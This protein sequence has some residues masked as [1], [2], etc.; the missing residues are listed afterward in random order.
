MLF[1]VS[2]YGLAVLASSLSKSYC[3]C[4]DLPD[5]GWSAIAGVS[6]YDSIRAGNFLTS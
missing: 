2:R 4:V 1:T 3:N 6:K 5:A